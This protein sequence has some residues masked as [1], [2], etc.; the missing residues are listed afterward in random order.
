[1]KG[2]KYGKVNNKKRFGKFSKPYHFVVRGR[3]ELPTSG[4]GIDFFAQ[5]CPFSLNFN[6]SIKNGVLYSVLFC[7]RFFE[8]FSITNTNFFKDFTIL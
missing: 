1:M 6:F 4:L 7:V 8:L 3:F 2:W 5:I